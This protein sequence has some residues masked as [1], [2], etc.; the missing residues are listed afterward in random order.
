MTE[1][2]LEGRR[3]DG[4]RWLTSYYFARAVFSIVWVAA[5]FTVAADMPVLAGVLLVLYPA[6]DA[7]ANVEDA[8]RNGG[9]GTTRPNP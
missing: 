6:W 9:C 8:R 4:R 5:A 2:V 1:R 7:A 3:T